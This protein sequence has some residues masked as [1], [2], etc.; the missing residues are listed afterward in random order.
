MEAEVRLCRRKS[1]FFD[2][3]PICVTRLPE[4][5]QEIQPKSRFRVNIRRFEAVSHRIPS[6]RQPN[7]RVQNDAG[8]LETPA[9][10]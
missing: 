1:H 7:L 6:K 3:L 5:L 4:H 9:I 8:E 10:G 2:A